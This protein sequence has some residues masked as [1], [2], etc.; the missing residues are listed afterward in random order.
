MCRPPG[1]N[2]LQT[3]CRAP[4]V[5]SDGTSQRYSISEEGSPAMVI[6]RRPRVGTPRLSLGRARYCEHA[7]GVEAERAASGFYA[8][9]SGAPRC[10]T[11]RTGHGARRTT[12]SATL[13]RSTCCKPVR[14]W[15]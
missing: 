5:E 2:L 6:Q 8:P 1:D 11:V 3:E 14:P 9:S 12:F 15:V 4:R 10:L 13:P 7:R